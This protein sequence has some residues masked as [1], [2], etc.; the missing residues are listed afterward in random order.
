MRKEKELGV[1]FVIS[2]AKGID[3]A[4]KRGGLRSSLFIPNR[5]A[6]N[7]LPG[8]FV[9]GAKIFVDLRLPFFFLPVAYYFIPL[10]FCFFLPS[11]LYPRFMFIK[12]RMI[13]LASPED[14]T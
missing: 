6:G 10:F 2:W 3:E 13:F 14:P 1:H 4:Q 5:L 12:F 8:L 11:D 9:R 7:G